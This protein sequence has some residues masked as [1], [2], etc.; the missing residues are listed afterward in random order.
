MHHSLPRVHNLHP[1]YTA[2]VLRHALRLTKK[3]RYNQGSPL[4]RQ[5]G[6][7]Y[8]SCAFAQYLYTSHQAR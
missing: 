1:L 7:A 6:V 5:N 3:I 2:N 8:Q 4:A